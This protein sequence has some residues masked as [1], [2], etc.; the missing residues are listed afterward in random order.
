MRQCSE[1][2]KERRRIAMKEAAEA[3]ARRIAEWNTPE[4]I[5]EREEFCERTFRE[6]ARSIARK[7]AEA[8]AKARAG[9]QAKVNGW[10][11]A[12]YMW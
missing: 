1:R 10:L 5:R 6:A 4:A 7:K 11:R 3:E 12:I 8:E 9:E 2:F